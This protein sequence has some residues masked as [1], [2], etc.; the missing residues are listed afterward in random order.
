MPWLLVIF[1]Y[2]QLY[3]IP[4]STS[5]LAKI[6]IETKK[7]ILTKVGILSI[8]ESRRHNCLFLNECFFLIANGYFFY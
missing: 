3:A 6:A 8:F 7:E 2:S 4:I 5:T 1:V